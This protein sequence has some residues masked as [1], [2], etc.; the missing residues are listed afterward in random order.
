MLK[1]T[2]TSILA[3]ALAVSALASCNSGSDSRVRGSV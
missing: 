3:V 2:L 1:R